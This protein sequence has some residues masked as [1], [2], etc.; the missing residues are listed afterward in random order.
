MSAEQIKA[1]FAT[2]KTMT[3][4]SFASLVDF[5]QEQKGPKGDP[6]ETGPIGPAGPKGDQ[7]EAGTPG[8]AGPKGDKGDQGDQG[9]PGANGADG[10]SI[11]AIVL[12]TNEGGQVTGG[13]AT[14]SDESTIEITVSQAGA[15]V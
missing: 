4:E 12:R 11:K 8:V 5:L 10:K 2:G 1:L 6:G 13:T 15:G 14:L 3:Q 7:G 9:V